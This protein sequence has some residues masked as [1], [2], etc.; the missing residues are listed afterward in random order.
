MAF[1]LTQGRGF[2]VNDAKIAQAL[3]LRGK[4]LKRIGFLGL[5]SGWKVAGKWL[6]TF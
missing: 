1:V 2:G 3:Q 6:A 5:E 4:L